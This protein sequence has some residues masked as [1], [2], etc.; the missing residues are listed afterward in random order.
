MP[1]RAQTIDTGVDPGNPESK[2]G[3]GFGTVTALLDSAITIQA[4]PDVALPNAQPS[5]T[6]TSCRTRLTTTATRR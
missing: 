3:K 1:D 4:A 5:I 2:S 6:A